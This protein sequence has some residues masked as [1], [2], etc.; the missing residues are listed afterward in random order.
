MRH[1]WEATEGARS[2]VGRHDRG[3]TG[4]LSG[5]HLRCDR[6]WFQH[7][8]RDPTARGDRLPPSRWDESQGAGR[9]T[10]AETVRADGPGACGTMRGMVR[11]PG[12]GG[13]S[14]PHSEDRVCCTQCR[15]PRPRQAHKVLIGSSCGRRA[16]GNSRG[17]SGPGGPSRREVRL[18]DRRIVS[19]VERRC[20]LL[21][22]GRCH[23]GAQSQRARTETQIE[24]LQ[25]DHAVEQ[26]VP[27][28]GRNALLSEMTCQG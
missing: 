18:S 26:R 16:T 7:A 25:R 27:T 12:V 22:D 28:H 20:D 4:Y 2:A 3:L 17:G 23:R 9:T 11:V 24:R 21:M 14:P 19:R 8:E 10:I 5:S 1:D 6:W 15:K 13:S